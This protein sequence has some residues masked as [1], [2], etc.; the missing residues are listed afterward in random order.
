MKKLIVSFGLILGLLAVVSCDNDDD[1]P[2]LVNESEV[3][4]TVNVTLTPQGGGTAVTMTFEDPDGE[5]SGAPT[6]TGGTLAANTT[7]SGTIEFLDETD[8]NDVEDI[9]EEVEEEDDEHE[10]FY[11]PSTGLNITFSNLDLDGDG[12]PL[13]LTFTATTGAA[14]TGTLTVALIHEGNKPNDGTLADAG[15]ETDVEVPF[16]VTIQ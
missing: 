4:T 10:V 1:A 12:N 16:P 2:E 9:T 3:I 5:G 15:G 14:S 8:P 13:G 6:I 11:L 7:Y